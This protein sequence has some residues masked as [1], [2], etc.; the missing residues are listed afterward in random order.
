MSIGNESLWMGLI[1]RYYSDNQPLKE[2]LLIHSRLVADKALGI[3]DAH[4]ELTVDKGFI[5]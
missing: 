3:A 2:L 1:D 4:P 5:E